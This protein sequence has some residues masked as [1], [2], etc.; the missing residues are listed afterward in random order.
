MAGSLP[1]LKNLSYRK[2]YRLL[3]V[4]TFV[5]FLIACQIS[6]QPT[7]KAY[8]RYHTFSEQGQQETPAAERLIQLRRELEKA[9]AYMA[10]YRTD[11]TLTD[12]LLTGLTPLCRTYGVRIDAL[13]PTRE[14]PMGNHTVII[15]SI[16][17]QGNYLSLLKVIHHL[18]YRL[19]AGRLASVQFIVQEDLLRGKKILYANCYLQQ[20][21]ID[22]VTSTQTRLI[23]AK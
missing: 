23:S 5:L 10:T 11:S 6:L 15:R 7:W 22:E 2:K 17:L 12:P 16:R 13:T 20:L 1:Y 3:W 21:H 18:E 14:E 4:G 8:S 19:R 9:E